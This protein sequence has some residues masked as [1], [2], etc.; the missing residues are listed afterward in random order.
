MGLW[1]GFYFEEVIMF[2]LYLLIVVNNFIS[3]MVCGVLGYIDV[4]LVFLG[5][6]VFLWLS[7][8][9]VIL[10]CLCSLGELFMVLWILFGI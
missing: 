4:G 6:G 7:F 5:V 8:E 2:G 10:Q 9:L 3:V 1:C